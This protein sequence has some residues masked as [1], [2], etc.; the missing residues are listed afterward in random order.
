MGKKVI[1]FILAMAVM[2]ATNAYAGM[3][4]VPDDYPT[5]QGAI[6]VAVDGDSVMVR[7]GTYNEN[8]VIDGKIIKVV[9]TDGAESTVID[10]GGAGAAVIIKN[11]Q[12]GDDVVLSGFTVTNGYAY[13]GG[14][15]YLY[16]SSPLIENCRIV[17]NTAQGNGGGIEVR[18]WSSP[19]ISNC[20]IEGNSATYRG[21]GMNA[22]YASHPRV[23]DSV[24]RSNSANY[25]G[26]AGMMLNCVPGFWR[27]VIENNTAQ[28]G[29]GLHSYYFGWAYGYE[30]IIRGNTA[31]QYGGGIHVDY[32]G[33][34]R[35]RNILLVGN[36][37]QYGGGLSF[38]NKYAEM[39]LASSTIV[40]NSAELGGGI[41]S[42][43][44][45]LRY[46]V[47]NSIVYGNS[48][49]SVFVVPEIPDQTELVYTDFEDG[50][51]GEGN[52]DADPL[53]VDPE[54]GDYS[55]QAGSP[56]INAGRSTGYFVPQVDIEGKKRIIGGEIDMGA[57]EY[58]TCRALP[59]IDITSVSPSRIWP[60]NRKTVDVTIEGT[61]VL[62]EGCTLF[63]ASYTLDDEYNEL[64]AQGELTVN[65]DG[66]FSLAVPVTAWRDG[67]D[68]DGRHY[69][70]TLSVE[71]E[72]G[73]V[74]LPVEAFVPH[75][76][77]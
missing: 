32:W 24:I 5:I 67:Q 17:N 34:F 56:C 70:V 7:P 29:G 21:G 38:I 8:I 75:N 73:P 37:A 18:Y 65:E 20:L 74:E 41:F 45:V 48:S 69:T 43:G 35:G 11:H 19:T 54:N 36:S 10:A 68:R 62:A 39:V 44:P 57:Y 47:I 14:G 28:Y 33:D 64:S 76:D 55:L 52:I 22:Y 53:F 4:Y 3:L 25:G 71:N 1:L 59:E 12:Y 49:E 13:N 66:S 58:S 50:V 6:D 31:G 72:A 27:T 15:I 42:A 30:T 61:V 2:F 40:D 9:S 51:A 23:Y 26:G 77:I 63:D 60:P 46:R 16:H